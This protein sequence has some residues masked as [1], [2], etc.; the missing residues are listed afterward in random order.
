MSEF[1]G[2]TVFLSSTAAD[3]QPVRDGVLTHLRRCRYVQLYT[4]EDF[5]ARDGGALAVCRAD[6]KRSTVFIGLTGSHRGWEPPGDNQLRSITEMEYDWA[7]EEASRKRLMYLFPPVPPLPQQTSEAT[8]RQERFRAR[9]QGDN[10]CDAKVLH[11]EL[12]EPADIAAAIATALLNVFAEAALPAIL[13]KEAGTTAPPQQ[14]RRGMFGWLFGRRRRT[15]DSEPPSAPSPSSPSTGGAPAADP[16]GALAAFA[17][18]PAYAPVLAD[19]AGFDF[20]KLTA[21]VDRRAAEHLGAASS[22]RRAA[23]RDYMRLAELA[24]GFEAGK[25]RDLYGRAYAADPTDGNALYRYA[26][27]C[28]ATGRSAEAEAAFARFDPAAGAAADLRGAY[29][30]QLGY[31][32]HLARSGELSSARGAYEGARDVAQRELTADPG[33][34][35]WQRDLSV[36]Y[37]RVGNVLVAQGQLPD[38]LKAYRDGLAIA[39]RLAKAD[40]GNA[41]WQRDLSVSY[42]IVGDVLV[43]QGQLPGALKAFRDSLAIAERLAKADP[44][45]AGWQRDLSVSYNRVGDVLV[46]Q[47]QLPGALKA[48]RDGQAIFERLAKADPGNTEWQR[49]L[50]VSYIK[51]GDVLVAQGQLPDALK[52]YRDSLA[53]RERLAKADPGN[54]DWQRDLSVSYNKVGN[55]LVAQGNLPDALKAFRDS[56]AIRERLAKADPGNAGWQRDLALSLWKV[57]NMSARQGNGPEALRDFKRGRDIIAKLKVQSP[58]TATYSSDLAWVDGQIAALG[59]QAAGK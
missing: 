54:A 2:L 36:S 24:S 14:P 12:K 51:V 21:A 38:A 20:D 4:M 40:P 28:A 1:R 5:G 56:L 10:V 16:F 52:A 7:S 15:D 44:G 47:G 37:D 27:L 58:T 48:F 43:A 18:D 55:V 46:A 45:N 17:H 22:E 13:A 32:D 59:K 8:A 41:G 25:A 6:V 49:D 29:W 11:G 30:A 57:A 3:L 33:N 39:E 34:T 9:V 19:P 31:G 35:E 50:S 42:D 23:A 26:E 53:I